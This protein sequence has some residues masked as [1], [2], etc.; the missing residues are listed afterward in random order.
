MTAR[1]AAG[2][3]LASWTLAAMHA[4]A[5]GGV[6]AATLEPAADVELRSTFTALLHDAREG[7][8][9]VEE[10]GFVVR[11]P[12]GGYAIVRW[13]AAQTTDSARWE[14]RWPPGTVAI[15]HTHPNW[16]PR[17]SRIDVA[18]AQ[19]L[20]TAVFVITHD[21]IMRTIAGRCDTVWERGG[22]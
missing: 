14:G 13:P 16:M 17:P 9:N 11:L 3:L 21:R 22:S 20:H 1:R 4:L 5:V 7:S 12:R 10:A 2:L 6:R 8:S 19:N 18:T 15:V